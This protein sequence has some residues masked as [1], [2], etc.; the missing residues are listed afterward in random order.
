MPVGFAQ[1][2]VQPRQVRTQGFGVRELGEDVTERIVARI[3]GSQVG[4]Q[5]AA[6]RQIP[7]RFVDSRVWHA[8]P[9]DGQRRGDL[10]PRRAVAAGVHDRLDR[11]RNADAHL[12]LP[13]ALVGSRSVDF[14]SAAASVREIV[15]RKPQAAQHLS[16]VEGAIADLMQPHG[17]GVGA[18]PVCGA[19]G[20]VGLGLGDL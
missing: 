13:D 7:Q 8:R 1:R 16:A 18:R 5:E 3:G 19:Q 17:V 12:L 15:G 6:A 4:Q 10:G 11:R 20:H 2:R 14:Q 9:P